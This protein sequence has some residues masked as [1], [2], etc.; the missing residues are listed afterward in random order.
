M[1]QELAE[2]KQQVQAL[3]KEVSRISGTPPRPTT[4][5]FHPFPSCH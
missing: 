4:T 2:L 1:D 5:N 3:Q